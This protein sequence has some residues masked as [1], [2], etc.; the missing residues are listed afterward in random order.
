MRALRLIVSCVIAVALALALHAVVNAQ[1]VVSVGDNVN[2]LPVYKSTPPDQPPAADDYLRGNLLGQRC[3]EPSIGIFPNNRQTMM[4]FCNDYRATANFDDL[5]VPAGKTSSFAAA[6]WNGFKGALARLIG[7]PAH[8]EREREESEIE[9]STEAGIGG[10]VTYDGGRT[11]SG[12]MVPGGPNDNT[13]ASLSH[14]GKILG[15]QGYSD[16]AACSWKDS[17]GVGY[18]GVAYIGFTRDKTTGQSTKSGIFFSKYGNRNNSNIVHNVEYETSVQVDLSQNL[19]QGQLLDKV[20]CAAG[21]DG[22]LYVAYTRFTGSS[23]SSGMYLAKS[24]DGGLT[25]ASAAID[26][27]STYTQ[28]SVTVVSPTNATQVGVL[29]RTF[30]SPASLVFKAPYSKSAKN[31]D[32]F[33]GDASGA[34]IAFDQYGQPIVVPGSNPP[35]DDKNR[36][37]FRSL[38]FPA[39]TYTPDGKTLVALFTEPT[40]LSTGKPC[41]SGT[42]M[43]L[44]VMKKSTDNGSTWSSRIVLNFANG[45][46]G[47]VPAAPERLGFFSPSRSVGAQIQPAIACA[48]GNVCAVVWKQAFN[49]T[50]SPGGPENLGK[51]VKAGFYERFD[52]R[53]VTVKFNSDGSLNS[54][55]PSFQVSRYGYRELIAANGEKPSDVHDTDQWIEKTTLPNGTTYPVLDNGNINHTGAGLSAFTGDYI[56]VENNSAP[57]QPPSFMV[58]FSDNR[59]NFWAWQTPTGGLVAPGSEPS[60]FRYYNAPTSWPPSCSNSL[61]YGSR[62]QSVMAAR[63][64]TGALQLSGSTNYKPFPTDPNAPK[65]CGTGGTTQCIEFP[66]TLLN[67]TNQRKTVSLQLTGQGSFM[68]RPFDATVDPPPSY[69]YPLVNGQVTLYAYGSY[70]TVVYAFSGNPVT[71]TA[72][73]GTDNTTITFNDP[74]VVSGSATA[75]YTY[76]PSTTALSGTSLSGRSLSGRSLSGRSLSGRSYPMPEDPVPGQTVYDVIDTAYVVTPNTAGDTSSYLSFFN[77]D[78]AFAPNYVFTATVT[79]PL[80]AFSVDGTCSPFNLT[81]GGLI[82]HVSDPTNPL[83]ALSGRSLSGRSLSG[84][85]AA[86]SDGQTAVQATSFTLASS[87]TTTSSG[88]AATQST[89]TGCLIDQCTLAAPR[90]PDQVTILLRAYQITDNATIQNSGAPR[91]DPDGSRT[92]TATPPSTAVMGYSCTDPSCVSALGPDLAVQTNPA[93]SPVS[94]TTVKAGGSVA[95]PTIS[96]KNIGIDG[97]CG[98]ATNPIHC[99]DAAAHQWAVYASTQSSF[100]NLARDASGRILVNTNPA[101]GAITIQLAVGDEPKLP[102]TVSA[103]APP[104]C[105]GQ[106]ETAAVGSVTFPTSI[107]LLN[108]NGTGTYYL[109]FYDDWKRSVNELDES[110]NDW[111]SSAIT[112]LP[113]GYG[114]LGLQTPCSGTTCTK[115]G[116]LPIAWQFTQAPGSNIVID[117]VSTLPRVKFYA[118]CPAPVDANGYPTGPILAT[119]VPN[120]NDLTSGS[121]GWQYF[122]NTGMTRPQFT[123]QL[124]FDSTGLARGVCYSMWIEVPGTNQVIGSTD[125]KLKPFGPFRITPQ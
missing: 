43:P 46:Q 26:K 79:S 41:T 40:N 44:I 105:D 16:P 87:A 5:I 31:V 1:Q 60:Y 72:T 52:V 97:N 117:S 124:N 110:N 108:A 75:N 107:P 99:G 58:A 88:F 94:P 54:V 28:G 80:T 62:V 118:S 93:P 63:I 65:P 113:P 112:V 116:T 121:S 39:A 51:S 98:T 27:N 33:A 23:G 78:P 24:V 13:S 30:G 32:L 49:S 104:N 81:E 15:L 45:E 22:S 69:I 122:P 73:S 84:R 19:T 4:I 95:F 14:P 20:S 55:S 12:L 125:P 50:M 100:D 114:F 91:Y 103:T 25:W 64:N 92:G 8:G 18:V 101:A 53:G 77:I 7:R 6:I 66:V 48:P 36:L 56:D 115:T 61:N 17:N 102:C 82:G 35:V 38:A 57:G 29:W 11:W 70:S 71:V 106:T 34:Y 90:F 37:T 3:N 59:D 119:T 120:A 76:V 111:T 2:I 47:T 123:W 21:P 10:A 42:C 83:T 68:K 96:I 109:H 85:S 9:A 86:P 89:F 74:N 67:L